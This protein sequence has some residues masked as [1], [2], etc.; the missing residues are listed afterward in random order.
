MHSPRGSVL[1][2]V[3]LTGACGGRV[4]LDPNGGDAAADRDAAAEGGGCDLRGFAT[5]DG[6]LYD[7]TGGAYG[8]P[9]ASPLVAQDAISTYGS[10]FVSV[11]KT[12][13]GVLVTDY[14]QTCTEPLELRPGRWIRFEYLGSGEP[15]V[16][17]YAIHNPSTSPE[18]WLVEAGGTR[19]SD[20]SGY[21]E[22]AGSGSLTVSRADACGIVLSFDLT[23]S[24][25]PNPLHHATGRVSAPTCAAVG[26]AQACK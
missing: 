25:A 14:P 7:G 9:G 15:A 6:T 21:S 5:I 10:S 16:G 4:A 13:W 17:T 18:E 19:S 26:A 22:P 2:A 24:Y 11:D 3:A 23:F 20:C 12:A 8:T 1:L